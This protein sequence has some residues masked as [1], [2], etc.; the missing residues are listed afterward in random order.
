MFERHGEWWLEIST[1]EGYELPFGD[2]SLFHKGSDPYVKLQLQHIKG[3]SE[4]TL[5]SEHC[6][7]VKF[8]T[9]RPVWREVVELSVPAMMVQGAPQV[10]PGMHLLLDV[11]DYDRFTANDLL[12]STWFSVQT[13]IDAGATRGAFLEPRPR[14][15]NAVGEGYGSGPLLYVGVQVILPAPTLLVL[16]GLTCEGL[17][18]VCRKHSAMTAPD[19]FV[20][21]KVLEGSP[22]TTTVRS[23]PPQEPAEPSCCRKWCWPIPRCCR[24][25]KKLFGAVWDEQ[26]WLVLPEHPKDLAKL[27]MRFD[28]VDLEEKKQAVGWAYVGLGGLDGGRRSTTLELLKPDDLFPMGGTLDVE[29]WLEDGRVGV[30]I[31]EAKRLPKKPRIGR[32]PCRTE[33]DVDL[34]VD[35]CV[36]CL[37]SFGKVVRPASAKAA[38]VLASTP[39]IFNSFTPSWADP[40]EVPL[41]GQLGLDNKVHGGVEVSTWHLLLE[42]WNATNLSEGATC[43][44]SWVWSLH[45]LVEDRKSVV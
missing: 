19:T 9:L 21:A 11:V 32:R 15:L 45:D 1:L 29:L 13:L 34:R 14:P 8:G 4:A 7:T 30:R 26:H 33:Q 27:G 17:K 10:E 39:V 41:P 36:S 12:G 2:V 40:L 24:R 5:L 16:Q 6:S 3:P 25:R 37:D 38:A 31:V 42:L 20:T 23:S 35:L 43:L 44:G 22:L 18:D 28:L